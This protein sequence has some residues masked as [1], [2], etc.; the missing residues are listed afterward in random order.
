MD[1]TEQ[2]S[3]LKDIE[4]LKRELKLWTLG[5]MIS[6][7]VLFAGFIT[8]MDSRT[9]S[10]LDRIERI[11]DTRL[12]KME[13]AMDTRLDKMEQTFSDRFQLIEKDIKIIEADIKTLLL[14][15]SLPSSS[16]KKQ[17]TRVPSSHRHKTPSK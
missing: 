13:Q 6:G 12:D 8:Y 16:K 4:L 17:K 5:M 15:Q 14:A 9:Q 1:K 7:F 10:R 2:V 11:L 3:I